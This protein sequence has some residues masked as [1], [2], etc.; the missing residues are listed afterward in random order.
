MKRKSFLALMLAMSMVMG[1][2]STVFAA[3]TGAEVTD[4]TNSTITG[5]GDVEYVDTKV[6]SVTL[7]TTATLG[8]TIDPQGLS[9]LENGATAS[10][11][12]LANAAGLITGTDKAVVT[13]CSSVPI[14][15]SV[16]LTGTG[17]A[18][19]KTAANDVEAAP[20][21]SDTAENVLLYALPSAVDVG[22]S[23]DN[24]VASTTGV[25]LS[26][27]A[28]TVN[29]VLDAAEYNYSKDDTGK[30]T[31][32]LKDGETGHGTAIAFEGLVNTKAD[33]SDYIKAS[34]PSTIGMTAVFTYTSTLTDADK[35][36]TTE[37]APYG[38]ME[39]SSGTITVEA[40]NAAP[41]FTAAAT[42]G[43][44]KYTAGAGELGLDK[45]ADILIWHEYADMW[46]DAASDVEVEAGTITY[47]A[48]TLA[49]FAA[50]GDDFKVQ[51]T[52]TN[53]KGE[54]EKVDLVV[55]AK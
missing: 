45:D 8:L 27:T 23:K 54:T 26:T 52:Y 30:A 14:K 47:K 2:A 9:A 31:Y 17:D 35:A 40:K 46:Y 53:G 41:V 19:F 32:T 13:N 49:T 28:A 33:W 55:K 24:Y 1:S 21:E 5:S 16:K 7:P 44:I 39:M 18:T 3:S 11:D 48:E 10:K 37:G 42:P 4:G 36:D 22:N 25:L 50:A 43:V 38:M 51:I 20:T 12:D 6:Y 29:F 15:V 34:S